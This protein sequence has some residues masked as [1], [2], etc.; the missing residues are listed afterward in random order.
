MICSFLWIQQLFC[1]ETWS[2]CLQ[3]EAAVISVRYLQQLLDVPHI[4]VLLR[5][6]S[7]VEVTFSR[8]D[9]GRTFLYDDLTGD[10]HGAT[11][12]SVW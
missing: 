4:S 8:S 1:V 3:C 6:Y 2:L 5:T 12:A 10:T 7:H 11:S 9:G